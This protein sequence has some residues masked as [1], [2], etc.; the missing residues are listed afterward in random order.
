MRDRAFGV[1][2]ILISL[3]ITILWASSLLGF[4][5][6]VQ[7][8]GVVIGVIVVCGLFLFGVVLIWPSSK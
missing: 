7:L 5:T 2:L 4:A 1:T 6:V 8:V 3:G